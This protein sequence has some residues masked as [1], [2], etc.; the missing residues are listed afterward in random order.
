MSTKFNGADPNT[1]GLKYYGQKRPDFAVVPKE[2]Q[3]SVWD[4]PRPPI[5]EKEEREVLIIFENKIIARSTNAL[6]V[7]ETASPPSIYIP[8]EDLNN[9]YLKKTQ[10]VS[11]C[12]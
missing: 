6:K 1:S 5:I 10:G 8:K 2:G 7:K 11:R 9:K 4:Y 12:E 3:E